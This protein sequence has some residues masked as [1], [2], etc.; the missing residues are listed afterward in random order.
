MVADP[1]FRKTDIGEK[2]IQT[3]N[4]YSIKLLWHIGFAIKLNEIPD[5]FRGNE[6]PKLAEFITEDDYIDTHHLGLA[7]IDL[8]VN[9]K[10]WGIW[11]SQQDIVQKI[12]L[13]WHVLVKYGKKYRE[14]CE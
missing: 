6:M 10:K 8:N 5:N 1:S 12:K 4:K 11:G 13:L 2:I 9:P 7:I 14:I 3:C